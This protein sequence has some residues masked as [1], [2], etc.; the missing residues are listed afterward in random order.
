M[1]D[2]DLVTRCPNC[3]T[4]FHVSEAQ[5]AAAGGA[6]RCGACLQ[7]FLATE[8]LVPEGEVRGAIHGAGREAEDEPVEEETS[9]EVAPD[10]SVPE[11]TLIDDE[12]DGEG[13]DGELNIEPDPAEIVGEYQPTVAQHPLA[14]AGGALLLAAVLV[15]QVAWFNRVELSQRPELRIYYERVCQFVPCDLPTYSDEDVLRIT[16]L[17]VRS[18]P[19]VPRAL[20][21]DAI[22]RNDAS[23][24]QRF[25]DIE[26]RFSNI[27]DKL[28]AERVFGPAEY[29]AG[30]MTGLKYIPAR[31]EVR[32]TLE[33]VDPGPEATNYSLVVFGRES[34]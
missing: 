10:A 11:L 22:I 26:L 34:R 1:S 3:E 21:V 5:L 16:D 28:L 29:L 6:V 8:H 31:T 20:M 9:G 30:E 13:F 18:H 33:I 27:R 24:R 4:S 17:V 23:W 2:S 14:W 15:A 32:I 12:F 19:S 25:P 7:V